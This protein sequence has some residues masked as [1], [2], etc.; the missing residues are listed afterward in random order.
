MSDNM[1][2]PKTKR[3]EVIV[4]IRAGKKESEIATLNAALSFVYKVRNEL[5][6]KELSNELKDYPYAYDRKYLATLFCE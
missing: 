2:T 1:L 4:A 3:Y 6:R 5:V